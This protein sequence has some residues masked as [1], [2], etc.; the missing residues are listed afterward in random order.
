VC[1]EEGEFLGVRASNRDITKRKVAELDMRKS[2]RRL[3]NAQ[4]V[5]KVGDWEWDLQ[6]GAVSWSDEMYRILGLDKDAYVPHANSFA[7]RVHPDDRHMLAGPNREAKVAEKQHQLEFRIISGHTD[8]IAHVAV[9][10]ETTLG[11]DGKP[12]SVLGTL[13]DMTDRKNWEERLR[14]ALEEVARL[15]EQLEAEN[16]YL[17]ERVE[18]SAA[19]SEGLVGRS[20]AWMRVIHRAE[21]VAPTDASVLLLGETG[22]GKNRLAQLIHE[23]SG[24]RGKPLVHVN[25]QALPGTLIESELFG[26]EKGAFTGAFER[27]IGRFEVANGGAVLLDEIGDLSPVLQGK[28]LRVLESGEFERVGSTRTAEVD[29]RVIAA[30]NR[31]LDRAVAEGRFRD[32][33]YYRI[34][35]FPIT[36]P[37][38]RERRDDIPLLTWYFITTLKATLGK[39]I[40]DVPEATMDFFRSYGWP[41]NVRELENMI[42]RAMILSHGTTL[43]LEQPTETVKPSQLTPPRLKTKRLEDLER[44]H[45]VAVLEECGWKIKGSG[46]AAAQ[47]G[48]HPSTLYARLKKLGIKRPEAASQQGSTDAGNPLFP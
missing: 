38:L 19:S 1:D 26:H 44:A 32:D 20:E 9:R 8:E 14:E 12:C 18:D 23:R 7:D 4:R 22:V 48:L 45:I 30:T 13:Q 16:V 43:M 21:Q 25:C 36:I 17:R 29:V 42:E 37:P 35:V 47:L 2:E 40:K 39:T 3:A 24:R 5:A 28:L 15:K 6:S 10:G 11:P 46:K 33:L 31:D 27:R 41:G 34:G